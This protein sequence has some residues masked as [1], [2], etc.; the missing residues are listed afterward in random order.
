[1]R[2]GV[3]DST[4]ASKL[5]GTWFHPELRLQSV[6]SFACSGFSSFLPT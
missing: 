2:C 1:M 4:V 5:Q 6:R 3:V